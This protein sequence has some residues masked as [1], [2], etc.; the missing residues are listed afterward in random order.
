MYPEVPKCIQIYQNVS[1][2]TKMYPNVS[3][4]T[5]MN[6]NGPKCIKMYRNATITL[7]SKHCVSY[8]TWIL[9]S[10]GNEA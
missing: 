3:N 4:F 2:F 9:H 7:Y 10:M 5:L 1:T 6:E 8:N